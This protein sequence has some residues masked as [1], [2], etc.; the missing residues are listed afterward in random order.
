MVA[1]ATKDAVII[2]GGIIGLSIALKLAKTGLQT[3]VF[4]CPKLAPDAS[5]ASLGVLSPSTPLKKSP[6][7]LLH[8]RSLELFPDYVRELEEDSGEK[9]QFT[10]SGSLELIP[11]EHQYIQAAAEVTAAKEQNLTIQGKPML[12]LLDHQQTCELETRTCPNS[13]GALYNRAASTVSVPN[14]LEALHVACCQSGVVFPG[15]EKVE[16]IL[17]ASGKVEGA[18]TRCGRISCKT[19]IVAAGAWTSSLHPL[20]EKYAFTAPVRGQALRVSSKQ[21]LSSMIVK[22]NKRYLVPEH[23]ETYA[24]GST[25][26]KDAGFATNTLAADL[27][28]IV[29]TLSQIL[30][31]LKYAQKLSSWAGLRPISGDSKPLIGPLPGVSGLFAATGHYKIGLGY[32][33]LSAQAIAELVTLGKSTYDVSSLYP[34]ETSNGLSQST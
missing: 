7:H 6:F 14:L 25:T 11:N 31:S 18:A 3:A 17:I 20:L 27:N 5:S 9:I 1:R 12:E 13:F 24:I 2:G 28:E 23:G 33:P 10:R 30:P 34:R 8:R 32:A 21:V 22:W 19:L 4:S 29:S 15:E 26:E 16:K